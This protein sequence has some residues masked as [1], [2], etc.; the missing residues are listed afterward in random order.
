MTQTGMQLLH[1]VV[2]TSHLVR[3]LFIFTAIKHSMILI[4][5][6]NLASLRLYKLLIASYLAILNHR[7]CLGVLD[8]AG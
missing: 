3:D 7:L 5:I 1:I 2:F 6:L 4:D 8:T